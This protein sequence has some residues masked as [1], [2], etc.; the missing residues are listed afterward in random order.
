MLF[1]NRLFSFCIF[2]TQ[3]K[4]LKPERCSLRPGEVVAV[5]KKGRV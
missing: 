2:N 4:L 1:G 5:L 3:E